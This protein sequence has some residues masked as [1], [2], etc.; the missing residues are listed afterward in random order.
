MT[1]FNA[2]VFQNEYLP[3]GGQVVDAVVTVTASEGGTV[4]AAAEVIEV[5]VIDV[6]GSMNEDGGAKIA[7]ARQATSAAI[8][9]LR[10]G[11]K[12]AVIAGSHEARV[13]Y[14]RA[15]R[16]EVASPQTRAEAQAAVAQVRGDGGTAMGTWLRGARSLIA[17]HEDAIAHAILLTDGRNEHEKRWELDAAIADCVGVFECD[18]RGLGTKWEVDELRRISTALL[19]TTDIIPS[20]AGMEAEFRALTQQTMSKSV[21]NVALRLWNP[22]GSEIEFVKQV[23]PTLEDLT[24]KAESVD[25][26]TDDYPLGSWADG[27]TRDYHVRIRIPLGNVGDERLAARVMLAVNG[28]SEPVA[29]VRAVWTNDEGLSTRINREVAHYTGQAELADAIATGLAA[30]QSGDEREATMRLG[31]AVQLAHE[32]GNDDTVKLLQRVV[33]VED[34]KTGTVR[35]K[36]SVEAV[37]EMA[38]DV[39][40]TRTVRVNRKGE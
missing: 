14:P 8:E 34:P 38:L 21:T 40:S 39:R 6:S 20:P 9:V 24:G 4:Q 2:N 25:A 32:N 23:A 33:E 26:L 17:G 22:K 29:L 3:E 28:V 35:L 19:G 31:R 15:P 1:Q 13:L 12:F 7:S 18:C 37:D 5:I 36:R 16:L 27:E 10:D 11:V 30:R